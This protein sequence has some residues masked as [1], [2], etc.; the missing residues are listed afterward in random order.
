VIPHLSNDELGK[1]F[2]SYIQVNTVIKERET[3]NGCFSMN[4]RRDGMRC[5]KK[6]NI[7]ISTVVSLLLSYAERQYTL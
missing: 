6:C 1:K 4:V 5:Y 7:N 2:L 3:D